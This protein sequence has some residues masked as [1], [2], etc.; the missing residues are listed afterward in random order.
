MAPSNDFDPDALRLDEDLL[1]NL[2]LSGKSSGHR[3]REKFL[4]GPIPWPWLVRAAHLPGR[5]AILS[6]LLWRMA[7]C[8]KSRTMPLSLNAAKE[9]GLS[10]YAVRRGVRAL[11]AAGLV[12]IRTIPGRCLEITILDVTEEPLTNGKARQATKRKS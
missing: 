8:R 1:A 6:L 12:S 7:G 9:L 5:A 11:K 2:Q 10:R 4:K 3:S